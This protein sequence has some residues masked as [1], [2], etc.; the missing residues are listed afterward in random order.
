MPTLAACYWSPQFRSDGPAAR[1]PRL[2]E[3]LLRGGESQDQKNQKQRERYEGNERSWAQR[4]C[5][6]GKRDELGRDPDHEKERGDFEHRR[7]SRRPTKQ[8][9]CP[10]QARRHRRMRGLGYGAPLLLGAR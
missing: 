4:L 6:V 9:G 5:L 8:E 2:F 3:K 1:A 7:T 10:P